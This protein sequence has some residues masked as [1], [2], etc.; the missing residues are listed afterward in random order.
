MINYI[1]KIYILYLYFLILF[2][3]F[4]GNI[5]KVRHPNYIVG[6]SCLLLGTPGIYSI[7]ISQYILGILCFILSI[8]SFLYDYVSMYYSIVYKYIFLFFDI[9]FQFIYI[10]SL[11][12]YAIYYNKIIS[13]IPVIILCILMYKFI[14]YEYSA[15]S[16]TKKQWI[17]RHCIWHLAVLCIIYITHYLLGNDILYMKFN[18]FDILFIICCVILIALIIYTKLFKYIEILKY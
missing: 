12:I 17:K 6:I 3:K 13:V 15:K 11:I 10:S 4:I 9:F 8:F 1:K 5:S 16:K 18:I 2:K 14:L 7:Y